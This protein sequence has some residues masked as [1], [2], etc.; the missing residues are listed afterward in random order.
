MSEKAANKT[1]VFVY[2]TLKAGHCNNTALANAE[3][4]G[5]CYIDGTY[6]MLDL[7]WYPA[8]ID[9]GSDGPTNRI[10]GEVYS[11]SEDELYSLDC[12]EGHPTFYKRSKIE[13][14]W[15]KAWCYFL[16]ESYLE[17][18]LDVVESGMWE[19][20]DEEQEWVRGT[21]NAA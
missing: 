12:I 18:D 13:T 11:V 2:G 14:P 5:R 6:T 20:S 1:R 19:P 17:R 8:V 21:S 7:G 16:P 4:L 3:Y 10:V 15:K 9:H